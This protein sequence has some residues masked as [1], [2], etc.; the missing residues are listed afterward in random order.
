MLGPFLRSRN[1][2]SSVS[3]LPGGWAEEL[4][5]PDD[6]VDGGDDGEDDEPEPEH[7]VDLLV[8]D[9][10]AQHAQ[11][12]EPLDG[13]GAS[14]LVE[15]A[16]RDRQTD[17]YVE[18]VEAGPSELYQAMLNCEPATAITVPFQGDHLCKRVVRRTD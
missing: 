2:Y 6:E 5:G 4:H 11:R 13:A 16:L 7:D 14:V 1:Q 3:P 18:R 8:E 10:H 17:M 9:V 12:V 15:D